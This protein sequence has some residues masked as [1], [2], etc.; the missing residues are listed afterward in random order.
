MTKLTPIVDL[1]HL[2]RA[3]VI[4]N[5]IAKPAGMTQRFSRAA[6][7]GIPANF[8]LDFPRATDVAESQFQ[9]LPNF[10]VS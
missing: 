9:N 10:L 6:D 4:L 3:P 7:P 5:E 1:G 8:S 2:W